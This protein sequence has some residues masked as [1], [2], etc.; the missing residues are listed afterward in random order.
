MAVVKMMAVHRR[1]SWLGE[2]LQSPSHFSEI[3]VDTK[4]GACY[5]VTNWYLI[6]GSV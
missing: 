4:I 6:V 3:V 1:R 5:V 2:V